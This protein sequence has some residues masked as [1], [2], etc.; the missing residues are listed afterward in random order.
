MMYLSKNNYFYVG[1]II[2]IPLKYNNFAD[3]L[4]YNILSMRIR[5]Y[6]IR[7]KI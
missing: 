6:K 3:S 1:I 2:G 7:Y 5:V 4:D